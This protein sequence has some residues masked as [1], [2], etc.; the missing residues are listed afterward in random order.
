MRKIDSEYGSGELCASAVIAEYSQR[1]PMPYLLHPTTNNS[2]IL[3][4]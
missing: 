1:T 3:Q 2:G 4:G